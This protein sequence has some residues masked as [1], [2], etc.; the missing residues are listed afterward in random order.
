MPRPSSSREKRV[1]FLPIIAKCFADQ[2]YRRTTTAE[3]AKSCGVQETILYRLWPGKK[4]M[5]LAAIEHVYAESAR[6]WRGVLEGSGESESAAERLLRYES[7]HLGEFGLYRILFAGLSET[8]DAE[9][10]AALRRT[11]RSF[12]REILDRITEHRERVGGGDR[13]AAEQ[14]AWA[15]LGVGVIANLS[16][17][18]RLFGEKDRRALLADVGGVLLE[19]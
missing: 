17:D 18:V 6:I 19:G 12:H 9:I 5:F 4:E 3:L 16:R 8:D 7:T 14:A 2:G 13:V 1:K 11:F 15:L 10:G